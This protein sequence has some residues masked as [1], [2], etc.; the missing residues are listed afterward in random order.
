MKYPTIPHDQKRCVKLKLNDIENIRS[1]YNQ[2]ASIIRLS[3]IYKVHVSTIQYWIDEN[4]RQKKIKESFHSIKIRRQQ[5]P[6]FRQKTNRQKCEYQKRRGEEKE[7]KDYRNK[8]R[9][10]NPERYKIYVK[11]SRSLH[12][13]KYLNTKKIYNEKNKGKLKQLYTEWGKKNRKRRSEN[14][15]RF[16]RA[17]TFSAFRAMFRKL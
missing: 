17:K 15:R 10:E 12:K 8:L 16:C 13:E 7:I 6:I 2:G 14:Q 5:D 9:E 11:K 3:E 4:Y 1:S